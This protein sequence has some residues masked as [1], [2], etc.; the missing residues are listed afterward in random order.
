[1]SLVLTII[2]QSKDLRISR[3]Y[4]RLREKGSN[5]SG[6]NVIQYFC[7]KHEELRECWVAWMKSQMQSGI[8]V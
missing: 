4:K 8:E 5:I 1:M 6:E 3:V 7:Q 2:C